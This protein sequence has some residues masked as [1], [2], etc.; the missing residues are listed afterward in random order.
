MSA[1]GIKRKRQKKKTKE[2]NLT[3]T[4]HFWNPFY[5]YLLV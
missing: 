1:K 4:P 3:K 5:L 2:M